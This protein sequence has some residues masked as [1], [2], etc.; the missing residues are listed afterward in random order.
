MYFSLIRKTANFNKK[1]RLNNREEAFFPTNYC[2][3][4]WEKIRNRVY[5]NRISSFPSSIV[6][7]TKYIQTE[8]QKNN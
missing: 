5:L 6:D 8:A 4:Y 1:S 3:Y 7:T 2:Y